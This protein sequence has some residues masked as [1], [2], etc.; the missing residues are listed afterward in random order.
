MSVMMVL[1]WGFGAAFTVS[2][3]NNEAF[4]TTNAR[5]MRNTDYFPQYLEVLQA[6]DTE[7]P[8]E[9][10]ELRTNIDSMD[11]KTNAKIENVS[12]ELGKLK[13]IVL[14]LVNQPQA[15]QQQA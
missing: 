7:A 2:M 12:A 9:V 1:F 15:W 4:F 3:P 5:D 14:Q 6:V 8:S 10:G 11:D 13:D